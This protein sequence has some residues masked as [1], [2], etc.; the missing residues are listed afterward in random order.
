LRSLCVISAARDLLGKMRRQ[1]PFAVIEARTLCSWVLLTILGLALGL[2]TGRHAVG[3]QK[4]KN[5]LILDTFFR[6]DPGWQEQMESSLRARV[7]WKVNFSVTYLENPRFEEKS[8]R[9]SLAETLR[10]GY[11]GDKPDLVMTVSEPALRFAVE[12]RDRMFPGVPIVFWAISSGLADQKMPGVT[13]VASATGV[14][15]TIDLALRLQPDTSAIAVITNVSQTEMDWLAAVRAELLHHRDKV[16]EIDLIGAPGPRLLEGIAALPPHTAA[17]FQLFPHDPD[18]PEIGTWDVLAVTTGRLPTY[19]IFPTLALDRGGIGGAY[20]DAQ[21]DSVMAGELAARVLK[22]ERPDDIPVVHISNPQIRVDWRA[23]R[24]WNIPESALPEGTV[25]LYREPT[26]WERYRRYVLA[27]I[28]VIVAQALLIAGLL[29]Q[30]ARKRKAEAILRESEER[31]R[32]LADATPAMIW[33][34]DAEGKITYVNSRALAFS[35]PDHPTAVHGDEWMGCI[36]PDDLPNMLNTIATALKTRQPFSYEYRLRRSDGAYRWM[37][38]VASPRVNGD[39]SF[40]GFVG[41]AIDTTDQKLAQQALERVSGQLLEAQEKERRRIARELHDN[42]C[43]RLGLLSLEIDRVSWS[44]NGARKNLEEI[45]NHCDDIA[46]E[47]QAISHQLHSSKLD[48]LGMVAA[49]KG[50]CEE[51]SKQHH[52]EV[53]FTQRDVPENLSRDISLSLFRVTQEALNNAVKYSGTGRF[54]VEVT[55]SAGEV[56]LDVRDGGKGFDVE[57]AKQNRGLGLVS[58]QERVNLVGGRFSIE[59]TPGKGTI[60]TAVVPLAVEKE[61]PAE[62]EA[63][64]RVRIA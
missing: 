32:L 35:G 29:W 16:R 52:V 41:S 19:S 13:G 59:S 10:R 31:F 40:A 51:F 38:D 53:E 9:D 34:C 45:R 42:I 44:S 15:Q 47:V 24:R 54:A 57:E 14:R 2:P 5:V 30:R 17:L 28:S 1:K 20:Y 7:P 48:Y 46:N 60:I 43:Q 39:G 4:A 6:Q 37:L 18:E 26:L 64:H 58:M 25:V 22:G 49:L 62:A 36:H 11:G 55:G 33:M 50:F 8:Y 3:Q 61:S 56:R 27:A 23:L 21:E 12:Y 63:V